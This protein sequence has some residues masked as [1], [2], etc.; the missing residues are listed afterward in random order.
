MS[1]GAFAQVYLCIRLAY[2]EKG[3]HSNL[4]IILDDA[5]EGYDDERVPPALDI[6]CELGEMRQGMLFSHHGHICEAAESRGV[7]VIQL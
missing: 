1:R 4:P 7:P 6:L 5:Y 3:A 2:A